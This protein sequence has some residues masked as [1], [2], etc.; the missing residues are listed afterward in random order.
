M[1]KNKKRTKRVG[2]PTG[3][4]GWTRVTAGKPE[5]EFFRIPFPDTKQEIEAQIVRQFVSF[6]Q[7][8]T[9]QEIRVTQNPE[10]DLDFTLHLPGGDVLL[11]LTEIV[12][13]NPT[14][15]PPYGHTKTF[16]T[17]GEFADRALETIS[18]KTYARDGIPKHLL[19]YITHWSFSPSEAAI[20]LIQYTLRTVE[21]SFEC[22]FFLHPRDADEGEVR[23]FFPVPDEVCRGFDPVTARESGCVVFNPKGWK[24]ITEKVPPEEMTAVIKDITFKVSDDG[25]QVAIVFHAE[26]GTTTG[27]DVPY[28]LFDSLSSN[29]L[30]AANE[31]F[32][33]QV[34]AGTLA[35]VNSV[36][37]APTPEAFRVI[38]QEETKRAL[39]QLM[40]RVDPNAPV[41]LAA[42]ELDAEMTAA[43]AKRLAEVVKQ[44]G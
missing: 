11:E 35:R 15:G 14:G 19:C 44:F 27:L 10:N 28:Q 2:K 29:L 23:C 5:A 33:K 7:K 20:L 18:S 26:D 8:E 37:A 4:L 21:H 17:A 6:W 12:F 43:L 42:F 31:A 36:G 40:G 22:I 9:G 16:M 13:P 1:K 41:G 38:V 39:V 25:A 30:V 32:G 24:V 34:A 3:D